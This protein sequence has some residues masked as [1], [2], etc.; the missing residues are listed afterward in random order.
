MN[1]LHPKLVFECVEHATE[2]TFLDLLIHKDR[3]F[4]ASGLFDTRVHQKKMNLYLYIPFH[5]FHTPAAKR[6]FIQ[7]ELMRYIRNSSA[8]E[9]Y[10]EL[11]ALF[12]RRLRDRGYPSSF[13]EPLF[14]SIHYAD[15]HYFLYP[16]KQLLQHPSL[17]SAPP[18]S[19]CLLKR[20]DRAQTAAAQGYSTSGTPL[21]FVSQF[22]PLSA[23]VPI[24]A[25]LT[26]F[27]DQAE[28]AYK[29]AIQRPIVA[30]QSMPALAK[31]LVFGKARLNASAPAAAH[32]STQTLIS[33][34]L[35]PISREQ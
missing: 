19:S 22:N 14:A 2:A 13:L 30:N 21:V 12:F 34:F 9:D 35:Q 1:Q 16:S 8:E 28:L 31:R 18:L 11:K 20:I 24:R 25:I 15:R 32:A 17:S 5:S 27:W 4:H 29:G 26:E 7:T 23:I 10:N 6:S 3:R 33:R